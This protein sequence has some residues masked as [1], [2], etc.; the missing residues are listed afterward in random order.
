MEEESQHLYGFCITV[1]LFELATHKNLFEPI[2][3]QINIVIGNLT[4]KQL[5][6]KIEVLVHKILLSAVLI[7]GFIKYQ[8]SFQVLILICINLQNFFIW[9]FPHSPKQITDIHIFYLKDVLVE[10]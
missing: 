1:F 3:Q 7:S 8:C 4:T 2:L 10:E 6:H 5:N 9:I